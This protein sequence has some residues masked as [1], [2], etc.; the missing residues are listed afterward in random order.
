MRKLIMFT[1]LL[2]AVQLA[3][4]AP[5]WA[6]PEERDNQP[7]KRAPGPDIEL[8]K[9]ELNLAERQQQL[10]MQREMGRLEIQKKRMEIERMTG[11]QRDGYRSHCRKGGKHVVLACVLLAH[12]LLAGWIYTDIRK[13]N[14]GSGVWI[15]LALLTGFLGALLYV[16]V[17]LGD[18]LAARGQG[19]SHNG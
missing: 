14:A 6:D 1:C 13:R 16:L 8:R 11:Q 3:H 12:L 9:A 7:P 18:S 5:P 15:I 19:S 10:D 17:R 2:L 4:A